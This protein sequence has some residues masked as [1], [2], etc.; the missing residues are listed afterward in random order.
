[1]FCSNCGNPLSDDAKFCASCGAPV[2][3]QSPAQ[4][5]DSHTEVNT[6]SV[7]DAP[8]IEPVSSEAHIYS[9]P[10][11]E[12]SQ[13]SASEAAPAMNISDSAA[14]AQAPVQS[15]MNQ[16]MYA[17]PASAQAPVQNDMNQQMYSN[18][19]FAQASAQNTMN[20][21]MYAAG[22]Q[23]QPIYQNT[24]GMQNNN[25]QGWGPLM[26]VK[27]KSKA[28]II[29]TLSVIAL[30]LVVGI[31]VLCLFLCGGKSG[32]S[33]A[34][35]AIENT[36]DAVAKNNTEEAIDTLYPLYGT[37]LDALL[38][39]DDDTYADYAKEY[40]DML[41]EDMMEN[42]NPVG[43]KF[44]YSNLDIEF[45]DVDDSE[46]EEYKDF[47][48]TLDSQF[49]LLGINLGDKKDYAIE[50]A[51]YGEGTITIKADGESDEYDIEVS[52]VKC[53]GSWYVIDLE[54]Y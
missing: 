54:I 28:P 27:K 39:V 16:Q 38:D 9:A 50:T 8:S 17:N 11:I 15:D 6:D 43:S 24:M 44:T 22:G 33:S 48:D 4:A 1:M 49:S 10:N 36:L 20:Q 25:N 23:A 47:Y 53:N 5:S 51:V 37:M 19:A 41:I 14:S 30:L 7:Y 2:A 42:M 31:V 29:I 18:P 3:S 34:N 13:F 45:E 35:K 52:I 40:R 26:P 21:Q 32:A 12:P 46:L